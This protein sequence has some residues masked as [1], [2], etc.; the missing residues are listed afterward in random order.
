MRF[1]VLKPPPCPRIIRVPRLCEARVGSPK[2]PN[3]GED[4]D[5]IGDHGEKVPLGHALLAVKEL[6]C[7]VPCVPYHQC[8]LV[9]VAVES[10][11][12]STRPLVSYIP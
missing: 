8:G 1:Y 12:R 4:P 10:K 9:A 5:A 7:P 3:E 2:L 6:A 11:L